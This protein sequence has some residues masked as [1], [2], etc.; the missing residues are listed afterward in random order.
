MERLRQ[1][2]LKTF[3]IQE[4]TFIAQFESSLN[5]Q[6]EIEK[7]TGDKATVITKRAGLI[8]QEV[9]DKEDLLK[10]VQHV[11][12]SRWRDLRELKLEDVANDLLYQHALRRYL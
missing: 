3:S 12:F 2:P 4:A 6:A 8:F 9:Y 10:A 5:A 7:I 11:T 1:P